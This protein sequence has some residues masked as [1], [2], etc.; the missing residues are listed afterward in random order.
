MATDNTEK[1]LEFIATYKAQ[2]AGRS[3]TI[4]VIMA[5]LYLGMGTVS[6]HLNKLEDL[7]KI[8]RPGRQDIRIPGE[9]YTAPAW[10]GE[11]EV[12]NG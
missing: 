5:A 12:M 3:P 8:T 4:R 10:L 9:S 1:V 2:H 11:S 6:H 7:G